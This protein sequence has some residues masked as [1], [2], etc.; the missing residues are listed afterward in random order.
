I[1]PQLGRYAPIAIDVFYDHLLTQHWHTLKLESLKHFT[2]NAYN[3]IHQQRELLPERCQHMFT[4]MKR[5]NWLYNYQ[6]KEG[7][8]RA[9]SGLSRRT[10]FDSK[11]NLALPILEAHEEVINNQFISFFSDLQA[12]C[13]SFLK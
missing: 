11:L 1:K 2:E 5:D 10:Q 12:N 9:L 4:Y 3:I 6:F 8:H 13:A 7:I